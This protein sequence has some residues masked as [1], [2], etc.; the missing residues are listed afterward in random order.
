MVIIC[1]IRHSAVL[2]SSFKENPNNRERIDNP[3]STENLRYEHYRA[4]AY[5][6]KLKKS[7]PLPDCIVSHIRTLYPNNKG[8][9]RGFIEKSSK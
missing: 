1:N 4:A 2:L 5:F 8:E 9:Y 3:P 6:L 7:S